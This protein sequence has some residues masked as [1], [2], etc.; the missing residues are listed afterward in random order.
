[1]KPHMAANEKVRNALRS[2]DLPAHSS[3]QF[4]FSTA[5]KNEFLPSAHSSAGVVSV[6]LPIFPTPLDDRVVRDVELL[7]IRI[8]LTLFFRTTLSES[9]LLYFLTKST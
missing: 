1:M 7:L 4:Q 2:N 5:P 6:S 3:F 9:S 8:H